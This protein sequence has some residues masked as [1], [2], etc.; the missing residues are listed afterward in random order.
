MCINATY[1]LYSRWKIYVWKV[2][3][4]DRIWRLND[5]NI[6]IVTNNLEITADIIEENRATCRNLM[7]DMEGTVAIIVDYREAKT[8]FSELLQVMRGNQSGKREDLNKKAFTI[9]VG[10]DQLLKMYR[11]SMRQ[12]QSGGVNIPLFSDMENALEA[13]RYH[14]NEANQSVS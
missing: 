2:W 1:R 12:P 14:L 4:M 6:I 11:D 9:F 13:A 8:N 3:G 5:E 10:K 7:K